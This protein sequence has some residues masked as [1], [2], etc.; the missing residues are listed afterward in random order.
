MQRPSIE[1]SKDFLVQM[2]LS[3]D[4]EFK[5]KAPGYKLLNEGSDVSDDREKVQGLAADVFS[6]LSKYRF[7]KCIQPPPKNSQILSHIHL[8][9]LPSDSALPEEIES[10]YYDCNVILK[11]KKE[12]L[13]EKMDGGASLERT[14]TA[15]VTANDMEYPEDEGSALVRTKTNG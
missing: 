3:L 10:N 4:E 9:L 5:S 6:D 7:L 1:I 8:F 15:R 13:P 2:I 11:L 14:R 12:F